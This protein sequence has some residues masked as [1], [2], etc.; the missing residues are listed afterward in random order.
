MKAKIFK[1]KINKKTY[2]VKYISDIMKALL[3]EANY[4]QH[5]MSY[6]KQYKL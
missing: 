1:Q 5:K 3:L 4:I 2:E 6:K